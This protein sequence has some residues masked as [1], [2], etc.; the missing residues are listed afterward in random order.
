[1]TIMEQDYFDSFENNL[2]E[3]LLG[4][5]TECGMLEGTLLSSSDIDDFWL[6]VAP[7]YLADAVT[8]VQNYPT[9]S[10]AWAAYLGLGVACGWDLDWNTF[11]KADYQY[12]LGPN[13]FD[14]MDDHIVGDILGLAID[15]SEAAGLEKVFRSCAQLSID[16]IRHE[17]VEPQSPMAFHIFARACKAMY[18]IGASIELKRLGYR[19]ERVGLPEC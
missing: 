4:I 8:Q 19:L 15:G 6:S 18:R 7:G 3:R 5:A 11:S 14:D 17:Q 12:F 9:V 16:L 10:L 13:G 1:M 2:Q